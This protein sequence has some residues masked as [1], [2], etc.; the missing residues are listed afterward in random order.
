MKVCELAGLSLTCL[1]TENNL[2]NVDEVKNECAAQILLICRLIFSY[3]ADCLILVFCHSKIIAK[4]EYR[5]K[6]NIK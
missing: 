2:E 3:I 5:A 4:L 1:A 6:K